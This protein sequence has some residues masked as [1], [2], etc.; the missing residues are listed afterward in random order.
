M[1][2]SL[3]LASVVAAAALMSGCSSTAKTISPAYPTLNMQSCAKYEII[4]NV[5]GTSTGKRILIFFGSQTGHNQGSIAN[6]FGMRDIDSI[7]SDAVYNAIASTSGA[8]AIMAP[9]YTV[10]TSGIPLLFSTRT[11]KVKGKAIKYSSAECK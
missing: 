9:S 2:K 10:T 7:K 1:I 6:S 4:G 3:T 11:V 8:D 5:E